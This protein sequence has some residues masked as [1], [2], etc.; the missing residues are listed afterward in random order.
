MDGSV[1][2]SK[3]YTSANLILKAHIFALLA[4]LWVSYY[5]I[6]ITSSVT[7]AEG[8]CRAFSRPQSWL[9]VKPGSTLNCLTSK[10]VLLTRMPN[11]FKH[12][13]PGIM[14]L[15]VASWFASH[16]VASPLEVSFPSSSLFSC[17]SIVCLSA[18]WLLSQR[19]QLMALSRQFSDFGL[20]TRTYFGEDI[21]DL[22]GQHQYSA[23]D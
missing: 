12:R 2:I 4:T 7:E 20:L 13:V 10:P 22:S 18:L 6:H 3:L 19:P 9:I 16:L 8:G 17:P 23:T 21:D 1:L 11:C 15:L 14:G 5:H